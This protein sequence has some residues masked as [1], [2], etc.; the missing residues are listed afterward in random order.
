[1]KSDVGSAI[2]SSS[3]YSVQPSHH[4][5]SSCRSRVMPLR[6]FNRCICDNILYANLA[7]SI[8]RSIQTNSIK[9]FYYTNRSAICIT[10]SMS[11][12]RL[13]NIECVTTMALL[14]SYSMHVLILLQITAYEYTHTT[15][16]PP[17]LNGLGRNIHS[18]QAC[19]YYIYANFEVAGLSTF[20]LGWA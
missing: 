9:S 4:S 20:G 5:S 18:P 11:S 19:V 1:M 8:I 2:S 10:T 7:Q 15:H 17:N 3:K 12:M 13:Q 14:E 6:N 16:T